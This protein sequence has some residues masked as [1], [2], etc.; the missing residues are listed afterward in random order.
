[1][2][3]VHGKMFWLVPMD[4]DA[5]KSVNICDIDNWDLK[6][7]IDRIHSAWD[8]SG[9]SV[10]IQ[11]WTWGTSKKEISE[12]NYGDFS[13]LEDYVRQIVEDRKNIKRICP[14]CNH[15]FKAHGGIYCALTDRREDVYQWITGNHDYH[16]VYWTI[17]FPELVID[18][19]KEDADNCPGFKNCNAL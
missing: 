10:Y 16:T 7:I 4:G 19:I 18:I 12:L 6:R 9:E 17:P 1:M 11:R 14:S 13:D 5:S 15:A 3:D 8:K 2:E